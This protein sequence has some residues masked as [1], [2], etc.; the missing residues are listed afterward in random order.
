M[1]EVVRVRC[2]HRIGLCYRDGDLLRLLPCDCND[3]S[4]VLEVIGYLTRVTSPVVD[5]SETGV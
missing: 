4:E 2:P 5:A 3:P 1:T